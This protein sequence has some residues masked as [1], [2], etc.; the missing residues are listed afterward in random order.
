LDFVV[1][2]VF[3]GFLMPALRNRP[4]ILAAVTAGV[5]ALILEPL[6][7]RL[8]FIIAIMG[9]ITMGVVAENRVENRVKNTTENL[10]EMET[11]GE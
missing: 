2:F 7:H 10:K 1:I 11:A 5:I 8:G 6:P 9:G 4:A 3:V